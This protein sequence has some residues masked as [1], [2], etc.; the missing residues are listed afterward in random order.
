[1]NDIGL[2]LIAAAVQ[3]TLLTAA[4]ILLYA[5]AA[6]RGPDQAAA[7]VTA[8]LGAGVLLTM[9]A[10]VPLPEL[11]SWPSNSLPAIA[12]TQADSSAPGVASPS[13]VIEPATLTGEGAGPSLDF[14]HALRQR[15]AQSALPAPARSGRWPAL[16]AVVVLAGMSLSLLRVFL[17]LWAVARCRHRS[18]PIEDS[19]LVTELECCRQAMGCSPVKVRESPDLGA[20]AT[21]GY[22]RP[23]VLLPADWRTWSALELRAVLAHELA[24]VQRRDYLIGFLA[25]LGVALHFYHPLVHWLAGRLRLQQELAADALG[26]R[27]A[28]GRNS[29]LRALS[30]L[31]LRQDSRPVGGLATSFLSAPGTLM[32]RIQMLQGKDGLPAPQLSR[33]GS[34]GVAA[35]MAV[36]VIAVSTL[37]TPG[38]R[39]ETAG[40]SAAA[41]DVVPP[42]SFERFYAGGFRSVRGFAFGGPGQEPQPGGDRD[43]VDLSYLPPESKGVWAIRP[44]AL[45]RRPETTKYAAVFD[46]FFA[47]G[48]KEA[49]MNVKPDLSVA[50]IDSMAGQMIIQTNSSQKEHPSSL[51]TSLHLIRA[52]KDFDWKKQIDKIMPG[53]VEVPCEGKAIYQVT[54]PGPVSAALFETCYRKDGRIDFCLPDGKTLVCGKD[55][56]LRRI[57]RKEKAQFASPIWAEDWKHVERGLLALAFD[58]RDKK[59]LEERRK[60]IKDEH[61]PEDELM[62]NADSIVLGV[63][64]ADGFVFQTFIR[65][66]NEQAAQKAAE[67]IRALLKQDEEKP[68][69]NDEQDTAKQGKTIQDRFVDD[70]RAH[71]HIERQGKL[72]VWRCKVTISLADLLAAFTQDLNAEIKVQAK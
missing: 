72:I 1:M 27:H 33:V 65:T 22:R 2:S 25:R 4:A 40:P 53:A 35:L 3:V 55:E 28:G 44:A 21:M 67:A 69:P 46:S 24:H 14:L 57:L 70:L 58:C 31:A 16:V 47:M 66:P 26:A 5:I 8:C 51:I 37:R 39:V 59:W 11:W 62:A 41:E 17:A 54:P 7:V 63:D 43:P 29:Y 23:L 13:G 45:F 56:N 12:E 9:L 38:Q 32:R 60:L 61:E 10:F 20:P 49:G 42:S 30:Q 50:D 68:K 52:I 48:F 6:R 64:Y 71:T 36:I 34:I 19:A 15:L 18:R